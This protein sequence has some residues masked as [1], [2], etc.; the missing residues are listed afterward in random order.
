M[1]MEI[2]YLKTQADEALACARRLAEKAQADGRHLSYAEQTA[3]DRKMAD[4]RRFAE[5]IKQHRG[6]EAT[7]DEDHDPL[8]RRADGQVD[9]A[10]AALDLARV[11]GHR[12]NP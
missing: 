8:T 2:A 4:A 10:V 11:A 3:F 12:M 6:N 1:S 9:S 7:V 5:Q